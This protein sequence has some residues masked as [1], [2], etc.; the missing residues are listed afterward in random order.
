MCLR[1]V[2]GAVMATALLSSGA[3]A[4]SMEW[5]FKSMHP[6]T[7][8][9]KLF[10]QDRNHVWPGP[11]EVWI[12]NDYETKRIRINCRQGEKICYSAQVRNGNVYWG[13]D[14][15]NR[16]GCKDCCNWCGQTNINTRILN[17]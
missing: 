14:M 12:L 4:T 7:V 15:S 9:V 13:T 17:P 2:R 11:D 1:S 8:D 16:A 10:S 5:S 3:H 6:N